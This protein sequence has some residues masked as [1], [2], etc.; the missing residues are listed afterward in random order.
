MHCAAFLTH[1]QGRVDCNHSTAGGLDESMRRRTT[2]I[3]SASPH[4]LCIP[5]RILRIFWQLK[6]HSPCSFARTKSEPEIAGVWAAGAVT[7]VNH[8]LRN[9]SRPSL[10]TS[11][12]PRGPHKRQAL[13]STT[14]E[15]IVTLPALSHQY[16][17]HWTASLEVRPPHFPEL[18]FSPLRSD[19]AIP[20]DGTME[21]WRRLGARARSDLHPIQ[22]TGQHRDR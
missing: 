11:M 19:S 22:S 5:G 12:P 2:S 20:G 18:V 15:S 8:G 4:P 21:F 1:V 14:G 7:D 13:S 3:L 6:P 17:R 9:A 16:V 10:E